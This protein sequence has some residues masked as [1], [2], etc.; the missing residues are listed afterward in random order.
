MNRT[1][2]KVKVIFGSWSLRFKVT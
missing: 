1:L 2:L